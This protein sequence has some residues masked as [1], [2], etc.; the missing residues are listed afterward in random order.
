MPV[1]ALLSGGSIGTQGAGKWLFSCVC[2]DVLN[3]CFFSGGLVY[4][5]I[6]RIR[7][8]SGVNTNVVLKVSH[9]CGV[10][11]ASGTLVDFVEGREAASWLGG[12]GT[13]FTHLTGILRFYLLESRLSVT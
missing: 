8:L 13:L 9:V 6:A 3:Q 11:R 4:A 2:S 10:V 1:E 12:R 7:L 5:V